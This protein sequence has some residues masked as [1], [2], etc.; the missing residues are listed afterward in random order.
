MKTHF[1]LGLA[2]LGLASGCT[3]LEFGSSEPLDT[4][5]QDL[6]TAPPSLSPDYPALPDTDEP[7]DTDE[8]GDSGEPVDSGDTSDTGDTGDTG[9]EEPQRGPK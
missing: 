3:N 9:T 5:T 4:P 7:V 1:F 8:P 2:A 6:T